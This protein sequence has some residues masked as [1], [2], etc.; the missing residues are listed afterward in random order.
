MIKD[1]SR[2]NNLFLFFCKYRKGR[3]NLSSFLNAVGFYTYLAY[4]F[5]GM[6]K[7]FL[8]WNNTTTTFALGNSESSQETPW[9]CNFWWN[10]SWSGKVLCAFGVEMFVLFGQKSLIWCSLTVKILL[11]TSGIYLCIFGV[12]IYICV[13]IYLFIE[14][15]QCVQ[16][17]V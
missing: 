15:W 4:S 14:L 6:D 13:R 2:P 9:C 17:A 8:Q 12:Y 7:R 5:T 11:Y 1:F 16:C 10:N 3:R